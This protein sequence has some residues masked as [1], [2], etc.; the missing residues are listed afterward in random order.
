MSNHG[1]LS[2]F[3][4][5]KQLSRCQFSCLILYQETF[6]GGG[7]NLRVNIMISCKQWCNLFSK[8][9]TSL[10]WMVNNCNKQLQLRFSQHRKDWYIVINLL[11][12]DDRWQNVYCKSLCLNP[13]AFL[14]SWSSPTSV[15]FSWLLLHFIFFKMYTVLSSIVRIPFW[16][17]VVFTVGQCLVI[18]GEILVRVLYLNVN[19]HRG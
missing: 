16:Y 3:C 11:I 6:F 13:G 14:L 7:I 4:Q 1:N 10:L 17:S 8:R 19:K 12:V 2:T 18:Q 5:L 15:K 9:C